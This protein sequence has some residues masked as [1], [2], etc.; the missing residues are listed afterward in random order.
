MIECTITNQLYNVVSPQGQGFVETPIVVA[1]EAAVLRKWTLR[2]LDNGAY[3]ILLPNIN[4]EL[5]PVVSDKK[6]LFAEGTFDTHDGVIVGGDSGRI[7]EW[8]VLSTARGDTS[9]DSGDLN[10]IY[11]IAVRGEPRMVWALPD[12]NDGTQVQVLDIF[13]ADKPDR[14]RTGPRDDDASGVLQWKPRRWL[15]RIETA[16]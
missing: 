7:V 4:D 2:K 1:N 10:G 12:G 16:E 15:W 13:T 9:P 5:Q 14:L 8:E 11:M 3:N 6:L